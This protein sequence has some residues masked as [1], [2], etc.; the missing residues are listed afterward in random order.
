M[1]PFYESHAPGTVSKILRAIILPL[2]VS[3]IQ[4]V[5]TLNLLSSSESSVEISMANC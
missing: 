2:S 1:E 3:D 4:R 5:I